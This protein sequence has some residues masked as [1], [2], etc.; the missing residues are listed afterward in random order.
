MLVVFG[1]N[2]VVV[3]TYG[4][5]TA[6]FHK[7]SAKKIYIVVKLGIIIHGTLKKVLLLSNK[8]FFN[9][10]RLVLILNHCHHYQNQKLTQNVVCYLTDFY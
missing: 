2:T 4:G 9:I 1:N 7:S 8:T 6:I 10:I 5:Y 3:I